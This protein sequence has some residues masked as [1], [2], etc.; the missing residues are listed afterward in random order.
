MTEF[1]K[2]LTRT[3]IEKALKV[4]MR[5]DGAQCPECPLY[6]YPDYTDDTCG[7]QLLKLAATAM[8]E[9]EL[10]ISDLLGDF[11]SYVYGGVPNPAP[12]CSNAC[13][14]CVD[15]RGWCKE[16]K[17]RCKGFEAKAGNING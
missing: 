15:A 6:A 9:D 14:E 5:E 4:R 10:I 13:A 2:T 11:Q 12:Y 1:G 8:L 7:R 17:D 3:E 16:Y